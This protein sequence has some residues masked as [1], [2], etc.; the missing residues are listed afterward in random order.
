MLLLVTMYTFAHDRGM[1]AAQDR[2]IRNE[3]LNILVSS[4]NKYRDIQ[5]TTQLLTLQKDRCVASGRLREVLSAEI[6]VLLIEYKNFPLPTCE[7]LN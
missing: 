4:I 3:D 5:I 6:A 1:L 2:V 7:E